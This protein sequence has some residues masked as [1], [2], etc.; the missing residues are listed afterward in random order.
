[1]PIYEYE[2]EGHDCLMC[3]GRVCAIQE[4]GAEPLKYCP[5]CG[6]DVKRVV[7]RFNAQ[8]SR[9]NPIEKGEKRGYDTYRKVEDGKWERI[10]GTKGPE[11]I[12]RPSDDSALDA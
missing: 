3:E 5:D 7:S 12:V 2:P 10:A 4:I 9:G 8:M 6:L 1:M 11:M